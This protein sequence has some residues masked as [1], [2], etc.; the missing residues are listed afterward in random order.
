MIRRC[1]N[2]DG[3]DVEAWDSDAGTYTQRDEAGSVVEQRPLTVDETAAFVAEAAAARDATNA[4]T[5]EDR[6][7]AALTAN[8]TFLALA[9][10][11]NAQVVAQV[12]LLTKECNALIRL[13]VSALDSTEGTS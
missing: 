1:V 3:V 12:R 5:L 10:P 11:T 4:T 9:S 7:R 8:A 13:A 2:V 6:A